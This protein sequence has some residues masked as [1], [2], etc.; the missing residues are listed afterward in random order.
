M[1]KFESTTLK[2]KF[3]EATEGDDLAMKIRQF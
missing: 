1:T 2:S 3:K